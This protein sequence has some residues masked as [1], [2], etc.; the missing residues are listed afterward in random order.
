MTIDELYTL[1]RKEECCLWIGAGFSKYAGYPGALDLQ[2]ILQEDFTAADRAELGSPTSLSACAGDYE[3]VI[4]RPQLVKKLRDIYGQPPSSTEHHNILSKIAHFKT[5]I[6]TNY[7]QMIENSYAVKDRVVVRTNIDI[8]GLSGDK[9][10][11]YKI[12]GDILDGDSMVISNADY[13]KHYNRDFKSPFW[14]SVMH[15]IVTKHIVFLGYGYEDE[16]IRADFDKMYANLEGHQKLRIMIAPYFPSIKLKKLAQQQIIPII[17]EGGAFL[18]G[19]IPQIRKH[20]P[21]DLRNGLV[22]SDV[23]IKFAR[24]FQVDMGIDSSPGGIHVASIANSNGPT[25]VKINLGIK[26]PE[27]IQKYRRFN[28]SY[29]QMELDLLS[30]HLADF[31]MLVTEFELIDLGFL[32]RF[33][34]GHVPSSE[35]ECSLEFP[36][37]DLEITGIQYAHYTD[38]PG[39]AMI[40]AEYLGF[41][42]VLKSDFTT[43]H[44]SVTINVQEPEEGGRASDYFKFYDALCLFLSGESLIFHRPSLEPVTSKWV[45]LDDYSQFRQHLVNYRCLR[46]IEK[47]FNISFPKISHQLLS[48]QNQKDLLK[49]LSIARQG[50]Y[51]VCDP[52]GFEFRELPRD[53]VLIEVLKKGAPEGKYLIITP[54][55]NMKFELF[56]IKVDPG[57]F[58]VEMVNPQMAFYD[59]EKSN[60]ILKPSDGKCAFRFLKFAPSPIID[61]ELIWSKK[62][63]V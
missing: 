3:A 30:E 35:G 48:E 6:T 41:R 55:Q 60:A 14:A 19:L 21:A 61:T 47:G 29:D 43:E 45:F 31:S 62:D 50:G 13:G 24:N 51:I 26:D 27:I 16:N 32:K 49:A 25:E 56:G 8:P 58:Q 22:S 2:K 40:R 53:P 63:A 17:S 5:I 46:E 10:R 34:V 15:E 33:T 44:K 20:L 52:D 4:G 7:D 36:E 12:H 37:K 54:T 59:A 38:I 42:I 28:E 57:E 18:K 39:K 23:A 11:I 9:T 1:L